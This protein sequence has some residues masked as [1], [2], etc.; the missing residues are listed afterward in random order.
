VVAEV[1]E[2][3]VFSVYCCLLCLTSLG[4]VVLLK[5]PL[6]MLV[7]LLMLASLLFGVSAADNIPAVVKFLLLLTC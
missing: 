5:E 3:A 2:T 1:S 4:S 7:S 6:I